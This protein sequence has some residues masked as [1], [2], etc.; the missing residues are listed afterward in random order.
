MSHSGFTMNGRVA[1]RMSWLIVFEIATS[2]R[3]PFWTYWSDLWKMFGKPIICNKIFW[4]YMYKGYWII[5]NDRWVIHTP[6]L[7]LTIKS[8]YSQH[9]SYRRCSWTP[10][11]RSSPKSRWRKSSERRDGI[12]SMRCAMTW[13]GPSRNLMTINNAIYTHV[14]YLSYGFSIWD[15]WLQNIAA[16]GSRVDGAKNRCMA[17]PETHVRPQVLPEPLKIF[18][19]QFMMFSSPSICNH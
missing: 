11:T 9:L 10:C 17:M 5:Y 12:Q 14:H 18:F 6:N 2:T 19:D 3:I 15:A 7:Y 13:D 8:K 16:F 1:T 4:L